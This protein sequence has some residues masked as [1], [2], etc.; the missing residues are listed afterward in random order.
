MLALQAKM[1]HFWPLKRLLCWTES[2]SCT[3]DAY[4]TG[5]KCITGTELQVLLLL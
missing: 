4:K 5:C 2:V 1:K 3:V